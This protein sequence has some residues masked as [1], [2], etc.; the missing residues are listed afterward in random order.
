[1]NPF[2]VAG[3]LAMVTG[4]SRWRLGAARARQRARRG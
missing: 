3:Q 4:G 2:S 1:M